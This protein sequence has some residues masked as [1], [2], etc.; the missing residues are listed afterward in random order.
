ML[1]TCDN[2]SLLEQVAATGKDLLLGVGGHK[3]V[4]IYQSLKF[5]D[6]TLPWAK[7]SSAGPPAFS[8]P[9]A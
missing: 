2:L 9:H 5:L 6:P 8:N 3:R 7:S 1:R 4:E